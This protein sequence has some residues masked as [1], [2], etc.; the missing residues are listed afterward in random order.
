[1]LHKGLI[2]F[3]F[4]IY[5][6]LLMSIQLRISYVLWIVV[7]QILYLGRW[8]ISRL[9]RKEKEILWPSLYAM[10]WIVGSG[11]PTIT[12]PM[13]TQITIEYALLYP[14]ST[15]I[16]SMQNTW[17]Q[18]RGI[19]SLYSAYWIWQTILWKNPLLGLH[20]TNIKPVEH[21]AYKIISNFSVHSKLG[22]INLG[23][24]E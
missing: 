2:I 1:M 23:T 3:L 24:L 18:W 16:V 10:H 14:N 6:C 12:P 5:R 21:V 9:L 17:G 20:Y 11:R 15:C 19:S 13:G 7:P 22:M 4:Y 8:N